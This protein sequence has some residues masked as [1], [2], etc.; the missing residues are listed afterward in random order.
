MRET[1]LQSLDREDPLEEGKA[2][3]S[4]VLAW[5]AKN[6]TRL[7]ELHFHFLTF[8]SIESVMPSNH[9]ILCHPLLFLLSV[10][11]S[12]RAREVPKDTIYLTRMIHRPQP[13]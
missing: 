10:F 3:H 1:R 9:L 6:Q 11:A 8:M 2:N 4:S 7:S 12:I 13:Y 5:V